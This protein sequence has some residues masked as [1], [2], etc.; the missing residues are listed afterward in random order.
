ML[1]TMIP[2]NAQTIAIISNNESLSPSQKYPRMAVQNGLELKIM[3][4]TLSG[5][6]C[7]AIAKH[8]KPTV[9]MIHLI[10][11]VKYKSLG[12]SAKYRW[13]RILTLIEDPHRLNRDLINENSKG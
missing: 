12:I 11:S 8:A 7:I 10:P 9:P 1:I 6:Y 13:P 3:K 5:I 2:M 4:K